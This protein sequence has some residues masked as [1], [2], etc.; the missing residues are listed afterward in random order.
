MD[1]NSQRGQALVEILIIF[2]VFSFMFFSILNTISESEKWLQKNQF[3]RTYQDGRKI[4]NTFKK[5]R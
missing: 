2:M 1:R 5:V 4:K 3:K